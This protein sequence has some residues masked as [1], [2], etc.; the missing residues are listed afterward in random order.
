MSIRWIVPLLIFATAA[1]NAADPK[2][3]EFAPPKVVPA[4]QDDDIL[5]RPLGDTPPPAPNP[6]VEKML[7]EDEPSGTKLPAERPPDPTAQGFFGSGMT[8]ST[9]SL[10]EAIRHA[11]LNNLEARIEKVGISVEDARVRNAYGVF[12]PE[13]SFSAVRSR[14]RTPDNQSNLTSA[15]AVAQLLKRDYVRKA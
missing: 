4:A 13:F 10:D 7:A 12:D 9:L 8:I 6:V 1:L 5:N 15:E 14:V 11:L 2:P 3:P